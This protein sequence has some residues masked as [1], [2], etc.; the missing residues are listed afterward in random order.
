MTG[1]RAKKQDMTL[2]K[3]PKVQ[4]HMSVLPRSL[5]FI[6]ALNGRIVNDSQRLLLRKDIFLDYNY[7]IIYLVVAWIINLREIILE[8][9]KK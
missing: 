8:R 5:D 2:E 1:G 4:L 7:L 3:Q 9:E 6:S